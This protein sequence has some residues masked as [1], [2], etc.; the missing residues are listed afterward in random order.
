MSE[1]LPGDRVGAIASMNRNSVEFFGYGVYLGDLKHPIYGF[2]NPKIKLD[3]GEIVWGCECWWDSEASI[4]KEL[5]NLTIRPLTVAEFR[6][7]LAEFGD[8]ED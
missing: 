6:G 3:S 2:N 5:E 8:S 1:I 4:Q 7:S